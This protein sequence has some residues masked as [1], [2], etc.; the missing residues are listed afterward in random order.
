MN[1]KTLFILFNSAATLIIL[2]DPNYLCS[3]ILPR[4]WILTLLILAIQRVAE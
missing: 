4:I 2:E 3:S 1:L